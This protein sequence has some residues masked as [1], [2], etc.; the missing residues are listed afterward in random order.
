MQLYT[1]DD[2]W[3]WSVDCHASVISY[4]KRDEAM[5]SALA[6]G[7]HV[8]LGSSNNKKMGSQ[9]TW[10]A[11][12]AGQTPAPLVPVN[13]ST[14]SSDK[15]LDSHDDN[16]RCQPTNWGLNHKRRIPANSSWDRYFHSTLTILSAWQGLDCCIKLWHGS[17][18]SRRGSNWI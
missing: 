18:S 8:P 1:Y 2:M 6:H 16:G 13:N 14:R 9:S 11:A 5:A 15:L 12:P 10:G 4:Q 17:S 7:T 3:L